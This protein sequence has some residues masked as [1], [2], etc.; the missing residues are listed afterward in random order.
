[1]TDI[2]D[3]FAD[4]PLSIGDIRSEKTQSAADWS[5]RDALIDCLRE[6]DAGRM[7]PDALIICYRGDDAD[8]PYFGK[9]VACKDLGIALGLATRFIYKQQADE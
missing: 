4:H 7:K 3:N 9:R 8:G 1:M 2:P 6:I 5:P